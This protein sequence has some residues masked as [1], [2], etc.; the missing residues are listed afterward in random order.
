MPELKARDIAISIPNK[1]HPASTADQRL[2]VFRAQ[3][4]AFMDAYIGVHT[5]PY[6]L[7]LAFLVLRS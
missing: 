6:C 7:Q 3:W 1:V 5:K 2:Q 4:K